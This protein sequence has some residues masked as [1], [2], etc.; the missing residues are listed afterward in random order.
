MAERILFFDIDGTMLSTGGAGQQAMELALAEEFRIPMPFENIPT[1]GRTDRGIENDIFC[2]YGIAL[3]DQNR[4]RFMR[5]Y[6]ERLPD[7]L[8]ELPG[9]LLPG[10]RELLQQLT[11]RNDVHLSLL[12]GNYAEGAW[13]KLQHFGI[14]HYFGDGG[15]YGDHHAE[16]NDVAHLAI[17][18]V[19]DVLQRPVVGAEAVVIGD[20]PADI[21]CA[22][23][24]AARA[25]A[26]ATGV[27][28]ADQLRPHAPDHLFCD[29]S[30]TAEVV[31]RLLG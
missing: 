22:R 23:A 11:E 2:R 5:A 3:T 12:T 25:I 10:V 17:R 30:D 16:R 1:A 13:M 31:E 29:L 27:Y 14:D 20:T 19:S 8:R 15:G 4:Q 28:S 6:L 7:C 26:V 21:R 24:I 9:G 18:S